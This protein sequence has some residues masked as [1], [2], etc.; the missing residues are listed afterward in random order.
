M[1]FQ[2]HSPLNVRYLLESTGTPSTIAQY[3]RRAAL[4]HPRQRV[5]QRD[6][7]REGTCLAR[8]DDACGKEAIWSLDGRPV[9]GRGAFWRKR[10]DDTRQ[11]CGNRAGWMFMPA[12][13]A[14]HVRKDRIAIVQEI[15]G[16]RILRKRVPKLPRGPGCRVMRRD[17]HVERAVD[18]RGRGGRGQSAA[19]M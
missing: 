6:A 10:R 11:D 14:G 12:M 1:Q 5:R 2:D 18:R 8:R 3:P 15:V 19:G 16:R 4:L 9:P 17:G 13:V 7:H